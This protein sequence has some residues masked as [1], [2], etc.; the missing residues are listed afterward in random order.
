MDGC[1][2]ARQYNECKKITINYLMSVCDSSVSHLS[3]EVLSVKPT[4]TFVIVIL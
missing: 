3:V 4:P 1:L 2:D